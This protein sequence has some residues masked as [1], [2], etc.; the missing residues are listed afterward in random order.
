MRKRLLVIVILAST[1]L[2]VVLVGGY[3]LNWSWTGLKVHTGS[4]S[5][6]QNIKTLWDWLELLVIPVTLAVG[7]QLFKRSGRLKEQAIIQERTRTDREIAAEQQ[8]EQRLQ[9][10]L[11]RMSDLLLNYGL[12]ASQ[13]GDRVQ[14]AAQTRTLTALRALDEYRKAI[15]LQFLY[16]SRLIDS[17]MA[18]VSL[19]RADLS[20]LDL[21]K[22]SLNQSDLR[23]ANFS[24]ANLRKADLFSSNLYGTDLSGANLYGA[25]LFKAILL[26][27]NGDNATL[28]RADLSEA[29]LSGASLRESV[30]QYA[31][32]CGASLIGTDF[33][34]ANLT[35]A[36]FS[37]TDSRTTDL[38][39]ADFTGAD[40]SNAKFNGA[41][42]FGV[43]F[44][45]AVLSGTDFSG[46]T[47]LDVRGLNKPVAP[48]EAGTV[49]SRYTLRRLFAHLAR[50]VFS[51]THIE[52][53][54]HPGDSGRSHR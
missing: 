28:T 4:A 44:T 41:Y 24:K 29:D 42:L 8:R 38:S 40:L 34:G 20:G 47:L 26:G 27:A 51:R 22:V 17:G 3:L 23:E 15:V 50:S 13:L 30:M 6:S 12:Q 10:Y 14:A 36:D 7:A 49:Q 19:G 33:R 35:G 11:D 54:P 39:G 46:A 1:A 21:Q 32:L 43:D 31:L 53:A 48:E 45:Y 16:D 37:S 5:G 2:V 18:L 25:A 9:L 52:A